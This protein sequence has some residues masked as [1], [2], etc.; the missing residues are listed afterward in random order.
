[1]TTSKHRFFCEDIT[2]K[3]LSEDE[4]N[5]A[6]KVLRLQVGNQIELFDGKGNS[7]MAIISQISKKFN[8]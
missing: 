2:S 5:H 4:S 3:T 7:A 6:A 1:M 8:P